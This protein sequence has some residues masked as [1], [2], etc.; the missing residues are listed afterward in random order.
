MEI[1]V[2]SHQKIFINHNYAMFN[3]VQTYYIILYYIY[4]C[5]HFLVSI[6]HL[7]DVPLKYNEI[8]TTSNNFA[9]K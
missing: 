2:R 5:Q 7:I 1:Y 4:S 6:K 3:K 9:H 8:A